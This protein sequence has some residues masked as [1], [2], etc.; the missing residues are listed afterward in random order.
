MSESG[1]IDGRVWLITGA[2]SGFGRELARAALD[3]GDTEGAVEACKLA[4]EEFPESSNPYDSLGEAYMAAGN[5]ELAIVNY[6]KSLELGPDNTNA[7][8]QLMVLSGV[9]D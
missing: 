9:T 6:A 2:S 4:V 3:T 7:V 8:R 5:T 1:N